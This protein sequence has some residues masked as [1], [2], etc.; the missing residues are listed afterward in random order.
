MSLRFI[1][2]DRATPGTGGDGAGVGWAEAID[3]GTAP[4]GS[5]WVPTELPPTF[6]ETSTGRDPGPFG[7]WAAQRARTW[8]DDDVAG[9]DLDA[10]LDLPVRVR[11]LGD[12]ID[13]LDLTRG[14]TGA[15]KDVG[16][17]VLA[18]LWSVTARSDSRP[19]T[20][21]TATSGDTGGAVAA[22][23][24]GVSGLRAVILFPLGRVSDVQRRQFTTRASTVTAV[25]V[26][27]TFDD[28]QRLAR[29]AFADDD[30]VETFALV[31]AN[32]INPGRLLPQTLYYGWVSA[33]GRAEGAPRPVVV[34]SGNLGNVTA[35]VLARCMGAELG[36]LHAVVNEN[37]ALVRAAQGSPGGAEDGPESAV[38]T[39]S[40]AMDVAAPSNLARLEWLSARTDTRLSDLVNPT[41]IGVE[42]A[43]D[44]QRWAFRRHSVMIDPHTATGV[45]RARRM[46]R[47]HPGARPLVVETAH[48]GKFPTVVPEV[49][50]RPAPEAE[51]L[52]RSGEEHWVEIDADPEALVAILDEGLGR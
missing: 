50:G 5:L 33:G 27:G 19:R 14:P 41:S 7:P 22:A 16:A 18:A 2:A 3:G 46:I 6:V 24:E 31:S 12:G 20:V 49:L 44:A 11:S 40:S 37:D 38:R 51:W 13:L 23:V 30:H 8:L 45:A 43:R 35:A 39:D 28:C 29:G 21:L 10:A 42:E 52:Q 32:S 17:R 4:D 9:A 48:P 15:F 25:G 26:R 36:D 1:G 34:P 47:D